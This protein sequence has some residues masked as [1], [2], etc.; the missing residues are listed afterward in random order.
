MTVAPAQYRTIDAL[1]QQAGRL[2]L[3]GWGTR[4]STQSKAAQHDL[5][6]EFDRRSEALLVNALR[7]AYPEAGIV[8]EEGARVE[9]QA[10]APVF[11]ID[12]LDGT[13][14][15]AHGLPLFAVSIGLFQG[16]EP[17][18]GVVH[19]PALGWTFAGG[20]GLGA[21]RDGQPLQVSSASRL[22]EALLVTG[23]ASTRPRADSNMPEFADLMSASRGVRR[24]GSAAL[25]LACVAAGWLDGFWE[26]DLKPW[27]TAGGVALLLGS[28]GEVT[29]LD[30]GA[31]DLHSG[32]IL[33]TNGPLQRQLS[34]RLRQVAEHSGQGW[35]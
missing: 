14:N 19:A 11:Y 17:L 15:F 5:V 12:P 26:R 34:Q 16:N 13:V 21:T 1:A 33:A 29:D 20:P 22:D 18:Y 7:A 24:L 23:F 30:G 25:D 3:E 2:L 32:R 9:T 28:G 35:P 4:P 31:F 6:T 10:N 27:D 8:A